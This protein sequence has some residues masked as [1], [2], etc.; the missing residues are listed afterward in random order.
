MRQIIATKNKLEQIIAS[1]NEL[2]L[3]IAYAI[4]GHKLLHIVCDNLSTHVIRCDKFLPRTI[5]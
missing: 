2:R 5:K 4:K 3:I 1:Y